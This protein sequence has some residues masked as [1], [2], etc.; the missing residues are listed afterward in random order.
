VKQSIECVLN[1]LEAHSSYDSHRQPSPDEPSGF[2]QGE[3]TLDLTVDG[4][5]S[6]SRRLSL[7]HIYDKL[8]VSRLPSVPADPWVPPIACSILFSPFS[9]NLESIL[10]AKTTR[11]S[12]TTKSPHTWNSTHYKKITPAR[13]TRHPKPC[14][15]SFINFSFRYRQTSIP[16]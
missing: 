16:G 5:P 14:R 6:L 7:L 15:L 4:E 2:L 10:C 8:P 9:R 11:P 1:T 12:S 13:P 3:Y